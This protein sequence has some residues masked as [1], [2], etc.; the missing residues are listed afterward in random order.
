MPGCRTAK[1][2][3]SGTHQYDVV[4][5][6]E[7]PQLDFRSE[8]GRYFICECKDWEKK[9]ADVRT[10][11][12]L[13]RALDSVKTRFGI[14]FSK[15]GISGTG[16]GQNAEREQLKVFQD[17]GTVIVVVDEDDL[18]LLALGENFV[19]LLRRKYER[20]RLDLVG[21]AA[22]NVAKL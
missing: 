19:S 11:A 12:V 15:R 8:F 22:V 21:R 9:K 18:R 1:G 13:C 10:M 7:G 20:V 4:C 2:Q 5:S 17:R 16:K 6:M 14:L 3:R